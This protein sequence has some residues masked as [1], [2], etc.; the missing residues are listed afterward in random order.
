[1]MVWLKDKEYFLRIYQ[2]L[3]CFL[4]MSRKGYFVLFFNRQ[5]VQIVW[6]RD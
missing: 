6:S 2:T 3:M 5:K 1:M 4:K